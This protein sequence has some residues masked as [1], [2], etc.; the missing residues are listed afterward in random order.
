M[1]ATD[2]EPF[3]AFMGERLDGWGL[4]FNEV[5]EVTGLRLDFGEKHLVLRAFADELR[6]EG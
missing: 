2:Q 6:V 1:D 4:L 5:G 3:A